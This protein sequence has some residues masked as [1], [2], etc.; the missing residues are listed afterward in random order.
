MG[1]GRLY[2]ACWR[3]SRLLF[4]LPCYPIFGAA[5]FYA[6]FGL[7]VHRLDRALRDFVEV[8]VIYEETAAAVQATQYPLMGVLCGLD[9]LVIASVW[10]EKMRLR[11]NHCCRS[12]GPASKGSIAARLGRWLCGSCISLLVLV[13][14]WA[15]IALLLAA[16]LVIPL[17][18]LSLLLLRFTCDHDGDLMTI[19][20]LANYLLGS[21]TAAFTEAA[22]QLELEQGSGALGGADLFGA[23]LGSGDLGSGDLSCTA[24]WVHETA[25][26]AQFTASVLFVCT[27]LMLLSQVRPPLASCSAALP[28]QP[29]RGPGLALAPA[30]QP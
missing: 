3:V 26:D 4:A 14:F 27:P 20:A 5:L 17:A 2:H 18:G 23:D 8:G 9:L 12:G 21:A 29:W 19:A 10:S 1:C 28:A 16:S 25:R 24:S 6:T 11:R 7:V 15:L 22:D 13:L 30:Y